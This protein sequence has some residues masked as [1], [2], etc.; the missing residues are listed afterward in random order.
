MKK[1]RLVLCALLVASVPGCN[2]LPANG[3][4]HYDISYGAASTML[5]E[6][7]VAAFNYV[8]VDINRLVLDNVVDIGPGSF[9]RTFGK[10]HGPAPVIRIG[11][12]DVV[13]ISV[14]ES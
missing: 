8:L 4:S 10:G 1:R 3:P 14:F 12:G 2:V 5:A 6:P 11:A 13:Q 9:F 7:S